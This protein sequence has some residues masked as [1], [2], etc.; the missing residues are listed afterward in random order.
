MFDVISLGSPAVDYFFK[1][2]NDFLAKINL[3]PEDDFLFQDKNV[4]PQ[5]IFDNLKKVA[6]SAG[7]ISSNTALVL[8][9]LGAKTSY[10]GVIGTDSDGDFW[11][12]Q[13]KGVDTSY[14]LRK[15]KM[16]FCVCLLTDK[17]KS[18]TF[19]SQVNEFENDFLN[20]VSTFFLNETKIIHIGPLIKDVKEGIRLTIE[21]LERV[22][23]PKISFSPSIFYTSKGYEPILPILKRTHILFLNIKELKY[24]INEEPEKGSKKILEFGPKIVVCTMAGKGS[25]ITTQDKQFKI[26]RINTKNIIDTTGAGDT[27]AA[28]FLYGLLNDKSLEWS[29]KFASKIAAKSLTDYGLHWLYDF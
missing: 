6:K 10:I 16:S 14:V 9:T 5:Y 8:S 20:N 19:L 21:L 18:R 12:S 2:N 22:K 27:Y 29:A 26:S 17:G 4:K 11:L 28:G 25:L 15:G 1:T 13:V 7:G 23:N 24:L 3:K